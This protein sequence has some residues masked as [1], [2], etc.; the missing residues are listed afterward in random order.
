[1]AGINVV[2]GAARPLGAAV[3]ESLARKGEHVRALVLDPGRLSTKFSPSVEIV[4][5]NPLDTQS[6]TEA[7]TEATTIF[8]CFE[9]PYSRWAELRPKIASNT[10]L[11]AITANATFVLASEVF[12][13]ESDNQ[14]M[15]KDSFEA[16]S[17]RLTEVVVARLPQMYGPTITDSLF[18][19]IFDSALKGKKAHWPGDLDAPRSLLY[20]NDAAEAII[21]LAS[22]REAFGKAWNIAGP[23]PL[24]GRRFIESAFRAAGKSGGANS[25]GRVVVLTRGLIDSDARGMIGLPYDFGK[26]FVLDGSQF[27][28]AFPDFAFTPEESGIE[29]TVEWY[30]RARPAR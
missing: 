28:Q 13:S 9:P 10:L 2:I 8:D 23:T 3:V 27:Q 20:L 1:M 11:T 15:E 24:S 29:Q 19:E 5:A 22:S 12:L 17:S 6:L 26:P 18:L 25:W 14:E 4:A 7:C 21:R 30:R 16:H